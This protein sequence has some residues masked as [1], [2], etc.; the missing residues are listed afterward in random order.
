M[1]KV[2]S[3][4][5]FSTSSSVYLKRKATLY[6]ESKFSLKDKIVNSQEKLTEFWVSINSSLAGQE[7]ALQETRQ[8]AGK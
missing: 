6:L 2:D 5:F 7:K 3:Y 4:L 8:K 1:L